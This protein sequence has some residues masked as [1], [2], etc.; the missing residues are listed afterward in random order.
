MVWSDLDTLPEGFVIV[1]AGDF[2]GDGVD[3]VLLRQ[4][5]CFGAWLVENGSVSSWMGLGG[6][7]DVTVSG[8]PTSTATAK[9]ISASAPQAATSV[10]SSSVP[11][12]PSS[13]ATTVPSE[14][15]GAPASPR[16]DGRASYFRRVP[17]KHRISPRLSQ[18]REGPRKDFGVAP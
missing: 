2:D 4:D 7:G 13:C 10:P 15:S 18:D 17:S 5:T 8:S 16:S 3:D 12:T 11:P 9:T 14:P 1:G 6:L